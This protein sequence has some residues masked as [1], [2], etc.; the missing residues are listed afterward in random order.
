MDTCYVQTFCLFP[1]S[2]SHTAALFCP[3]FTVPAISGAYHR[4]AGSSS[5][6]AR[7]VLQGKQKGMAENRKMR[8][9]KPRFACSRRRYLSLLI[10][11]NET[12]FDIK[13]RLAKSS[14]EIELQKSREQISEKW[15]SCNQFLKVHDITHLFEIPVFLVNSI[16]LKYTF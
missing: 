10:R 16:C 13:I 4:S 11:R 6:P 5:T 7:R 12:E 8:I 9:C 3:Y 2:A 1:L 14:C 15:L